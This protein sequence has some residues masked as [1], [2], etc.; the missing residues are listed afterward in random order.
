[1]SEILAGE[2][3]RGDVIVY[4]NK[5][6][7]VSSATH[8]KPGKGG[9]FAQVDMSDIKE[10]TKFNVRFRT[11]EKVTKAFIETKTLTFAYLD[12]AEFV[13][14]DETGE[15]LRLNED[16][17]GIRKEFLQEGVQINGD[18]YDETL[19]GL[20][21]PNNTI[22]EYTVTETEQYLKGRTVTQKDKPG[23]LSNGVK[24]TLPCYVQLNDKVAVDPASE[25]FVRIVDSK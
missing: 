3:R 25:T 24:I 4:N 5:L 22:L 15:E 19:I 17:L 10:G 13:L 6:C 16:S 11:E 12:D 2:I 8:V 20:S 14:M 23:I 21:W 9:A 18:F 7:K 1:M